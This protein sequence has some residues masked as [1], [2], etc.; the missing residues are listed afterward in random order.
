VRGHA[1]L[2]KVIKYLNAMSGDSNTNDNSNKQSGHREVS[3]AIEN[4]FLNIRARG[5]LLWLVFIPILAGLVMSM[6]EAIREVSKSTWHNIA[7]I[8]LELCLFY[9]IYWKFE[10]GNID[11]RQFFR[12]IS[13]TKWVHL[14]GLVFCLLLFSI[15]SSSLI[16]AFLSYVWPNPPEMEIL[17]YDP[18][19]SIFN[20]S[21]FILW[22]CVVAPI[23]EEMLFRGTLLSRWSAKWGMRKAVL[24]SALAFSILHFD[25]LGA[26]LF[27]L[28]MSILYLRTQTLLVPIAAHA[29]YNAI[30]IAITIVAAHNVRASANNTIDHFLSI[31][32]VKGACLAMTLPMIV[33]YL[34]HNWPKKDAL[35]PY[36]LRMKEESR[37]IEHMPTPDVG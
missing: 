34:Y 27:A 6:G 15:P 14:S 1:E 16:G 37:P 28:C 31:V 12:R 25:K 18:Q 2:P 21:I 33:S 30:A 17:S 22:A 23:F 3:I 7:V 32:W 9:R 4:P 19:Q 10:Q 36:M 20:R 13:N 29:F 5:L 35:S 11:I 24:I 8:L 26:F